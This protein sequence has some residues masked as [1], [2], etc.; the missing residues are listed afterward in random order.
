MSP[1]RPSKVRPTAGSRPKYRVA[2]ASLTTMA[3]DVP[4]SMSRRTN[5]R[6]ASTGMFIVS[7]NP[8]VTGSM[9]ASIVSFS[10]PGTRTMWVHARPST[11]DSAALAA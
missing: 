2:N 1:K 4:V 6:P 8:G 7:K 11:L 5:A 3:V 10:V 9:V